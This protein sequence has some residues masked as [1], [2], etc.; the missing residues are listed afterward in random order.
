MMRCASIA[1]LFSS[2]GSMQDKIVGKWFSLKDLLFAYF[3]LV[4]TS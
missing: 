3:F 4:F 1:W 2:V